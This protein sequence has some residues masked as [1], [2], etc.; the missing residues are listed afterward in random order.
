MQLIFFISLSLFVIKNFRVH[1]QRKVGN[2]WHSV[3][4]VLVSTLQ[5]LRSKM[6]KLIRFSSLHFRDNWEWLRAQRVGQAENN[7]P[8]AES[9]W[10]RRFT[11]EAA[12]SLRMTP[13][14]CRGPESPK[15][16]ASTFFNT[17]NLLPKE[18]RF[19]HGSAK[20]VSFGRHLASLRPWGD[21][22][23]AGSYVVNLFKLKVL[24]Q[25]TMFLL[26]W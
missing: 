17:V 24:S 4:R 1:C 3:S 14:H 16:V 5:K 8:G 9:L 10:G 7:S 13:N 22:V 26:P 19:E 11:A 23:Q 21:H 6:S 12:K 18:L 20:L 2:P 15:N 25:K